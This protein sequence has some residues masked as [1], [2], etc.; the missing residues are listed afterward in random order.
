MGRIAAY[1]KVALVITLV[2]V[3]CGWGVLASAQTTQIGAKVCQSN[4]SASLTITQPQSDSVVRKA[5]LV[6]K[7]TA[8]LVSQVE[9]YLDETYQRTVAVASSTGEYQTSI[10][11]TPGT[12]TIE[13]RGSNICSGDVLERRVVVTY[14]VPIPPKKP[15]TPSVGTDIPTVINPTPE[16]SG[17]QPGTEGGVV[18]SNPDPDQTPPEHKQPSWLA[19]V[20]QWIEGQGFTKWVIEITDV[21]AQYDKA[22]P[23]FLK[24]IG[25]IAGVAL[26]VISPVLGAAL[27]ALCPQRRGV[28]PRRCN[29]GILVAMGALL[30][31]LSLLFLL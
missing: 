22:A 20:G 28:D 1:A 13:A 27:P 3:W 5:K 16:L 10:S 21:N 7:G 4:S 19:R 26:I 31:L 29:I 9:I 23:N 17:Q 6:I 15:T 30:I 8:S 18:V 14:E 25:M 24:A 2:G 11:L 12:H